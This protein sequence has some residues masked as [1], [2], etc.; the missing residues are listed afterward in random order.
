MIIRGEEIKRIINFSLS[1]KCDRVG[2]AR[3]ELQTV[4]LDVTQAV[5]AVFVKKM[6]TL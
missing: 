1:K 6:D 4:K 5:P 3:I 2:I